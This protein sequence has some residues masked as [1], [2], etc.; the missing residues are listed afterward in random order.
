[1]RY[2][3][4]LRTLSVACIGSIPYIINININ[5]C[6]FLVGCIPY[7][8]IDGKFLIHSTV[9]VY[10]CNP[11][12][13]L[14]GDALR[15]CTSGKWTGEQPTCFGYVCMYV[16][17]VCLHACMYVCVRLR[18]CIILRNC[19]LTVGLMSSHFQRTNNC[20]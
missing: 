17:P 14:A 1:M 19:L 4:A 18:E 13:V 15:L 16:Q 20:N 12:F 8:L 2:I 7:P 6:R 10:Q 3:I 9:V 11:G 5:I